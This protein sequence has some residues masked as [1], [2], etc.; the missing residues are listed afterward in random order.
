MQTALWIL[1][2]GL[3][4]VSLI[5]LFVTLYWA[6]TICFCVLVK[7]CFDP[8]TCHYSN[9]FSL[10]YYLD[11]CEGG[12]AARLLKLSV[13]WKSR[14]STREP[15]AKFSVSNF[16]IIMRFFWDSPLSFVV[17]ER[18]SYTL[19]GTILLL[20]G[21]FLLRSYP[22][23]SLFGPLSTSLPPSRSCSSLSYSPSWWLPLSGSYP[24]GFMILKP[25]ACK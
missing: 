7:P 18:F 4:L 15:L 10:F 21:L 3:R 8:C 17:F 13:C 2:K 23:L 25:P 11:G 14:L 9:F 6:R 19:F 12:R 22:S 16:P 5:R 20:F 24:A 1:F